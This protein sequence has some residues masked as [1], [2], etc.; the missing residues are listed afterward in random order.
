VDTELEKCKTREAIGA[1]LTE[2][3]LEEPAAQLAYLEEYMGVLD[4]KSYCLNHKKI[5][6]KE[7]LYMMDVFA[8]EKWKSMTNKYDMINML[9]DAGEL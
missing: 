7:H 8:D 9:K 4:A 6:P 5:K 2:Q 3:G 1:Y